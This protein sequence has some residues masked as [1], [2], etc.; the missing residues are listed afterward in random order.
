MRSTSLNFRRAAYAQR[1]DEVILLLLTITHP[2]MEMPI[3]VVND[4]QSIMS[5]GNKFI[6]FPFEINLPEETSEQLSKVTLRIDNV[7]RLIVYSLRT[8]SSAPEVT[9]EAILATSPDIVEAGPFN[10]TLRDVKYD[11]L[12]VEGTLY[13]ED[14]L[15][16]PYPGDSFVPAHFPGLFVLVLCAKLIFT[17]LI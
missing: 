11:A 2:D 9:L 6:A 8:L 12:V 15:N 4:L 7:D 17:S 16:E 13:F 14:L 5:R 1:T 10:M 3:R